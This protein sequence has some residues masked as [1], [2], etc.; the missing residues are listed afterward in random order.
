ML[1]SL[2]GC[3]CDHIIGRTSTRSAISEIDSI[4]KR[5]RAQ[6]QKWFRTFGNPCLHVRLWMSVIAL[7]PI[8]NWPNSP[9]GHPPSSPPIEDLLQVVIVGRCE[10]NCRQIAWKSW[11]SRSVTRQG[12]GTTLH[13]QETLHILQSTQ[14]ETLGPGGERRALPKRW[15][16]WAIDVTSS[17]TS[18]EMEFFYITSW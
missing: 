9:L 17:L 16:Y 7:F 12:H 3:V 10:Y 14:M 11:S 13:R 15:I 5:C 18:Q 2:V 4:E 1:F 6:A 8:N